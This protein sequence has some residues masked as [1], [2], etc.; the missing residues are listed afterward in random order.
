MNHTSNISS[1]PHKRK[2]PKLPPSGVPFGYVPAF[3]PGSASLVEQLDRRIMI[4][5]R[6][7]RHL[8]GIMK[9]FDQFSNMVLEDT[10]ERRILHLNKGGDSICYYVDIHLGMYLVRGDSMVLLGEIEK[11]DRVESA[12]RM[13]HDDHV[14]PTSS[15]SKGSNEKEYMKEVTLEEFEKLQEDDRKDIVQE[16]TWEFDTDLI[17]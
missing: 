4:V 5:L 12:R 2:E 14:D 7:G 1:T 9:S 8:V 16:L 15:R 13:K 17:V 3:L 10:S 11:D 6:D